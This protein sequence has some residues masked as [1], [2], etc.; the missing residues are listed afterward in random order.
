MPHSDHSRQHVVNTANY[1]RGTRLYDPIPSS[2]YIYI[3]S[4][5]HSL[6]CNLCNTARTIDISINLC[7][8]QPQGG[9]VT[10][11]SL[12]KC[13]IV[14][15]RGGVLLHYQGPGITAH[16]VLSSLSCACTRLRTS[17]RYFP[18][19]LV[20][21]L[22]RLLAAGRG[23]GSVQGLI[24]ISAQDLAGKL[25]CRSQSILQRKLRISQDTCAALCCQRT[26]NSYSV[27]KYFFVL[28]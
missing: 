23:A 13:G 19:V 3:R 15:T 24:N 1:N 28:N 12:Q 18:V 25:S 9:R 5:S 26:I 22:T 27:L 4:S 17:V 6:F 10:E 8:L 21:M 14:I 20:A 2:L 7:L 11:V 16:V